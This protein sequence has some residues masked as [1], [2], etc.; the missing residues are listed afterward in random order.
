MTQLVTEHLR[1]KG[2]S[3][4]S[5]VVSQLSSQLA[6]G[7]GLQLRSLPIAIRVDDWLFQEYPALGRMQ[8]TNIERQ[9][10]EA[11]HALGADVNGLLSGDNH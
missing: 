6:S 11:M 5:S 8:K 7:L 9:L 1:E 2:A 10:N 3:Y 4:P